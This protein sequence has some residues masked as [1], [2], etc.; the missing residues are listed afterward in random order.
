MSARV[1]SLAVWSL[2]LSAC[3]IDE[4][5]LS[6]EVTTPIGL[7]DLAAYWPLDGAW[8]DVVHAHDLVPARAN[9]FS[10]APEIRGT[11]NVT[12]G[13]TSFTED[14]GATSASFTSIDESR[15]I[16]LEGW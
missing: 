16:T 13:P 3:G 15:G 6:V 12:Y 10:A 11:G 4:P 2:G 7:E 5:L 9:G 8:T 1:I 14:N